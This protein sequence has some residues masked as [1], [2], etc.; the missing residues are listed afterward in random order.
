MIAWVLVS[1]SLS[2]VHGQNPAAFLEKAAVRAEEFAAQFPA[3]VCSEKLIQVKY[4]Q[5]E[6]IASRRESTF[7]YLI[8]MEALGDEFTVEESR[9]EKSRPQ[10]EPPQALL[11]TTGF[12]VM[13]VVFHPHFQSSYKFDEVES[14]VLAGIAWRRIRF[15]QL[16]GHSSPTVLEV[17]GRQYP[18]AWRG[19]AW[20]HPETGAVKRIQTELR[21]P[22]PDIGLLALTSVVDYGAASPAIPVWVPSIA[23]VE[24]RTAHQHWRNQHTFSDYRKFDVSSEQTLQEVIK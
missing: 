4:G 10:K 15:E 19:I 21:E 11:A 1:G 16:A 3:L 22:L 18:I 20:L 17:K 7:D 23:V 9:L 8:L 2:L 5:A 13:Q 24:A 14:E 12:A 6:K